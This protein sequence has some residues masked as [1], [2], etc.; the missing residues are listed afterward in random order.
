MLKVEK[1]LNV[2]FSL[3]ETGLFYLFVTLAAAAVATR[4]GESKGEGRGGL[5]MLGGWVLV[6]GAFAVM[7]TAPAVQ[8]ELA[9]RRGDMLYADN[10]PA[11]AQMEYA[12]AFEGSAWLANSEYLL[13]QC[14]AQIEAGDRPENVLATLDRAVRAN[15][16][17]IAA[18]MGRVSAL[19]K[20]N[21]AE[22][23]VA[24]LQEACALSPNDVGIHLDA[25]EY[26]VR[27]GRDELA[28]EQ[29]RLA[30]ESNAKLPEG[31]PKRL[32]AAQIG[33]VEARLAALS[34]RR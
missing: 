20:M 22:E 19:V 32:T 16:R 31:E 7:V 14:K 21:K 26:L 4:M 5:V 23:A 9:S 25:A 10:H 17:S 33:D 12:A 11:R 13:R 34:G 30:L 3:F 6:A 18:R 8:G 29:Y 28:R 15:P 1:L 27:L 2:D 24:E